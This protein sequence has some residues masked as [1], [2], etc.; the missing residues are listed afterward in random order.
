MR[1]SLLALLMTISTAAFAS[2]PQ[3]IALADSADNYMK[4]ERWEAAER[5]IIKALRLEPANFSNSLLFSN[6][7]VAQTNLG[8]YDEALESFRLGLSIAPNSSTL[9]NNRARTLLY[10]GRKEEAL[11]DITQSLEIDSI[12][13][14]PMQMKG[15]LLMEKGNGVEAKK[16]FLSL[17]SHFPYNDVA[18]AGLGK[19]A[20]KEG[21][22]ETA[23]RYYDEALRLS[24]DP[25]TRSWRILLKISMDKYS[26]ASA[27]IREG[28]DRYPENPF[29]YIWRG[30]LHR[31]NYRQD[32]AEADKK[33]AITKGADPQFV[34]FYIP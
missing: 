25:E 24:D 9:H 20:E 26:D 14:W 5:T 19:I 3:Y 10:K 30:Y 16:I 18:M 34:K 12:Q 29:F 28:I 33:I 22:N 1:K 15:L 6:L 21:D 23:L 2:S 7:G 13:E 31:L 17:S 11:E 8:K 4:R 27:D 32:E